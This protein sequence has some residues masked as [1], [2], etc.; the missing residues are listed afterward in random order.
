MAKNVLKAWLVDNTVTTDDKMD[1]IFSLE[2][3]GSTEKPDSGSDGN[4]EE[5]PLG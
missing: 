2:T 5:N 1:K 3:T 4:Q